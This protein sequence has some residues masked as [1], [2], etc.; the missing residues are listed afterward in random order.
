MGRMLIICEK[1]SVARDVAAALY[2]RKAKKAGD[3][4]EGPDGIVAFAVGH[5]LEQVDPDEYDVKFKKW[6]YEDLPILPEEFHYKARD[7]RARRSCAHCTS[8]WS[9]NH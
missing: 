8:S 3:F 9:R 5:L 1:P 4:Y 6:R 7:S 2:G